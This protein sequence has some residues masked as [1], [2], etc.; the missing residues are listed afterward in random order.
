MLRSLLRKLPVSEYW[1]TRLWATGIRRPN[2]RTAEWPYYRGVELATRAFATPAGYGTA[3]P[4]AG[5]PSSSY[6]L[7]EFGVAG[8]GTLQLMLHFRDVWLRRLGL[9]NRVIGLGFDTFEGLPPPRAT[10]VASAWMEGDYRGDVDDVR[11]FLESRGFSDFRLVKGL[12]K[13]TLA[14]ERETLIKSP[15]VFVAVD[16]DYYSSTIDIFDEL[17]PEIAP[18]GCIFYFDDVAVDFFS[19]L[20][21]EL[22]AIDEVNRGRYGKHIQLAHYPLWIETGEMRHFKQVY[23]FIN[24]EKAEAQR[25]RR[26]IDPA[27]RRGRVS[28]L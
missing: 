2:G 20:T 14:Q 16:C 22:L 11:Q 25:A 23:R 21:G 8:G 10:D 4:G 18:H 9:K 1:K 26:A 3:F 28:P 12:F 13:E 24:V 6:S 7:L 17:L 19:D 5:D 15:P 27:P